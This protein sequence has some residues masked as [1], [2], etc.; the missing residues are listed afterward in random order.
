[1]F[2]KIFGRKDKDDEVKQNGILEND[3]PAANG[4]FGRIKE[5][6]KKTRREIA[7]KIEKVIFPGR[8]LDDEFYE[9]LEEILVLSDIGAVTANQLVSE[10]R[11]YVVMENVKDADKV[12][13]YLK[14]KLGEMLSSYEGH[15]DVTGSK[16]YVIMIVGV[17]GVGKT[18]TIGKLA[19]RFLNDGKKVM[20]AAGDTFRAAA[21]KQ[22]EI[23]GERAGVEV[24][25]GKEGA[26]PSSVA[27]D[28][29]ASAVSR[30]VDVL[31]VD[32]AGRMHV[33]KNLMEELKKMKRVIGKAMPDAPHEII[34]VVDATTGQNVISQARMFKD[35]IGLTGVIMTKLDGTAKGG[36]I[37]PLV[38]EM[39]VSVKFIGVGEDIDSLQPFDGRLFAE[40]LF[41]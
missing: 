28:S 33:K 13:S 11:K 29:V 16:P 1:M 34:M 38:R 31:I 20:L 39:G 8:V 9:E 41:D 26:D 37:V 27:F 2:N 32:T 19:Q 40:A 24:V 7:S 14:Q 17:N 36:V 15:I 21:D 18:T 23:W 30:G 5:G 3:E 22:L 25:K 12:K 4:F 6:L 35:E 10:L